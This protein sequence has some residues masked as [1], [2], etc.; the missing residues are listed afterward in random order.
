MLSGHATEFGNFRLTKCAPVKEIF[1]SKAKQLSLEIGKTR[2][3]LKDPIQ[4][5]SEAIRSY[6]KDLRYLIQISGGR[7]L[8]GAQQAV[9]KWVG[10]INNRIIDI[11]DLYN[12]KFRTKFKD[13]WTMRSALLTQADAILNES[14]EGL[15]KILDE[16]WQIDGNLFSGEPISERVE[17]GKDWIDAGEGSSVCNGFAVTVNRNVNVGDEKVLNGDEVY[18]LVEAV[19]DFWKVRDG[20]GGVWVVPAE[21]IVPMPM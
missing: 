19:G 18:V 8:Q 17:N 14:S 5:L 12:S 20:L 10:E 1:T 16:A 21:C 3:I 2:K 4:K 15:R 6:E 9:V 13:Y 7:F 11:L